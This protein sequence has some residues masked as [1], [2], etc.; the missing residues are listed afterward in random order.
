MYVVA[1]FAPIIVSSATTD[2]ARYIDILKKEEFTNIWRM[3]RKKTRNSRREYFQVDM[4]I[5]S[6]HQSNLHITLLKDL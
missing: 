4:T 3:R 1:T 5:S 6:L 2:I